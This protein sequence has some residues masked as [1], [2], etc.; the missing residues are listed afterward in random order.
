MNSSR[1]DASLVGLTLRLRESLRRDLEEAAKERGV[2]LNQQITDCLEHSRDRRGLLPEVLAAAFTDKTAGVALMLARVMEDVGFRHLRPRRRTYEEDIHWIE[3][4]HACAE[5]FKA[6]IAVLYAFPSSLRTAG[7]RGTG[8]I[9]TAYG[10]VRAVRQPPT[11]K[12][13]NLTPRIVREIRALLGP[14]ASRLRRPTAAAPSE[15]PAAE[16]ATSSVTTSFATTVIPGGASTASS[17]ATFQLNSFPRAQSPQ[18]VQ[19][20]RTVMSRVCRV[21]QPTSGITH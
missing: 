14:L 11:R 3:D 7:K 17:S 8:S 15:R 9:E 16:A 13:E 20:V 12:S 10:L 21:E 6:A 18:Q 2:S 1:D 19:R 4:P 5:A